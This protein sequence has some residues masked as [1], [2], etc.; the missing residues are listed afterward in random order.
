MNRILGILL[1]F[2]LLNFLCIDSIML[3]VKKAVEQGYVGGDS[4]TEEGSGTARFFEEEFMINST[5]KLKAD[6]T[7]ITFIFYFSK[8]LSEVHIPLQYPPPNCLV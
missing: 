7:A 1:C 3:A 5:L 4:E 2:I 8:R 6:R